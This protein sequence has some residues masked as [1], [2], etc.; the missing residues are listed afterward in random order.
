MT[1]L[2]VVRPVSPRALRYTTET[3]V[4]PVLYLLQIGPCLP[5][6]AVVLNC[7]S[8]QA[9]SSRPVVESESAR[10]RHGNRCASAI[11]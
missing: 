8:L 3:I 7:S 5:R 1:V 11:P 6:Y 4:S 9:M 10:G 2:R